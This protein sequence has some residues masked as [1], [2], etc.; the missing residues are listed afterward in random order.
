MI[1]KDISYLNNGNFGK[2]YLKKVQ[3]HGGDYPNHPHM[4][5]IILER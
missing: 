3:L 2:L 1:Q 4:S 5:G